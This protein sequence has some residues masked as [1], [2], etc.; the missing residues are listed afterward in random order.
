[1]SQFSD[2]KE[3]G[4]KPGVWFGFPLWLMLGVSLILALA[5]AVVAWRSSHREEQI[6]GQAFRSRAEALIW[7]LEAG[8][9]TWMGYQGEREL[10]QQ[11]VEETAKQPGTVYLAVADAAGHIIS[12]S[13]PDRVGDTFPID[14]PPGWDKEEEESHWRVRELDGRK[15]FE[16]RR[17]FAPIRGDHHA[18]ARYQG[19]HHG[20]MRRRRMRMGMQ[21]A[22][23]PAPVEPEDDDG[24][25]FIFV[26][27][28]NQPLADALR[29]D[30]YKNFV[31]AL[32]VAG[33][34]LAGFISMFWYNSHRRARRML[35]DARALAQE[36]V[37]GLPLGLLTR[38]PSGRVG[39][40]N[41]AA[42]DLLG[43]TPGEV[44]GRQLSEVPGLDWD[45]VLDSLGDGRRVLDREAA[46]SRAGGGTL[47]NVAVSRVES[48]DG[49]FLG[50]LF[51]LHDVGELKRLQAEVERNRR[52]T[53]LG[54]LA[55]GVAHE[56]RNPLSSIKGLATF[57]AGRV[58]AEGPEGE[59]ARTMVGEVN[60]LSRVVSELLDYARPGAIK[61]GQADVNA[62]VGSALRLADADIRAK[63][64]QVEFRPDS[65]LGEVFVNKERL[66]QALLNLFLNAV[67]AMGRGGVLE[68]EVVRDAGGGMFGIVVRDNG[69]GM[70]EEVRASIFTPYFT[71][72]ASGTGLGLA[73]VH[74]IV[75][76]HG[77]T[78]D[79]QSRPGE[80]SEFSVW[81]PQHRSAPL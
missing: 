69:E 15:V 59:A 52:L 70:P 77:G 45:G 1:M 76:G 60:R 47:V 23:P 81:L 13:D 43:R 2:K 72:K 67:Q 57:L 66:T 17:L 29:E 32:A 46:L 78:I 54:N 33:L 65:G 14:L 22:V 49:A 68:V 36:V 27:L 80:G 50:H 38:D 73:I 30:Y 53:E 20:G 41:G 39:L 3:T 56:I 37:T 58:P 6:M 75:E 11:L 31:A 42:L 4:R 55:A 62:V 18:Y 16:V 79:V 64:I 25:T 61:L 5:V 12:H 19:G 34:A 8:S 63:D 71:T 40:V 28:D 51:I 21:E 10:M 26:G 35:M 48:E 24:R 74:Q 44:L 9:R 7:A